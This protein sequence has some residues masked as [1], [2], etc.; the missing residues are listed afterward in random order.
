M[1]VDV[2][3][4][5]LEVGAYLQ[6]KFRVGDRIIA[7]ALGLGNGP[8]YG[9]FQLHPMV[10]AETASRLPDGIPFIQAAVLP[11]SLSIA[12]VGLFMKSTLGLNYLKL[13]LTSLLIG[14]KERPMLLL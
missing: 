14:T 12:A 9:G 10:K 5:V 6:R 3:G 1:G 2:A 8:A 7:H 11:L 4:I 13:D